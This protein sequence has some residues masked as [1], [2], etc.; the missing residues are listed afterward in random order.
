[1]ANWGKIFES[2]L[3]ISAGLPCGGRRRET[4]GDGEGKR[5]A[6]W[7]GRW[8]ENFRGNFSAT[9]RG[10]SWRGREREREMVVERGDE[11]ARRV[12]GGGLGKLVLLD[13]GFGDRWGD[14]G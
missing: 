10:R 5:A 11:T 4:R 6:P 3:G 7:H 9:R 2:E 8:F 1:M 14:L 13:E 12:G